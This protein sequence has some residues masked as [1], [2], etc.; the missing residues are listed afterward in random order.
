MYQLQVELQTP[1]DL[2]WYDQLQVLT[3]GIGETFNALMP[4]IERLDADYMEFRSNGKIPDLYPYVTNLDHFER[5]KHDLGE[6]QQEIRAHEE[7]WTISQLYTRRIE[8]LV[9][10]IDIILAAARQDGASFSAANRK[11]YGE[12]NPQL[13]YDCCDWIRERATAAARKNLKLVDITGSLI[14]ML[15]WDSGTAHNLFPRSHTFDQVR[16]LHIQKDGYLD[17]LF[18]E[19]RLTDQVRSDVGDTLTKKAITNVGS[20]FALVDSLGGLWS[21]LQSQKQVVRPHDYSLSPQAFEGIVAHEVGSHLLESTNG[22]KSKLKL[23][24]LGLYHYEHGNEGRAVIREQIMYDSMDEYVYQSH[25]YPTKASWEYRVAIYM[26]ITLASGVLGRQYT[27]AELYDLVVALY[28]F[29]TLSREMP[30]D[31]ELISRGAWSLVVRALKGTSG[32]GGAYYKDIVYLEGNIACWKA[33]EQNPELILYG[34]LGKF[35]IANR[36]HVI[37]LGELGILPKIS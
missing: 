25:W 8:E 19:M 10:N 29:W 34:D 6:L 15:P 27:F 7:N 3:S 11:A 16:N 23:L 2:R 5:T 28:T 37:M 24:E 31:E 26:V 14:N 35:D 17:Q 36:E 18:G 9:T 32:Q 33:A 1:L 4:P 22:A 20:D 13:F 12:P 30:I 21:V